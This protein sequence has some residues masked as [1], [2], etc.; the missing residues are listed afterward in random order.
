MTTFI[1][2]IARHVFTGTSPVMQAWS[3]DEALW[4][5]EKS[6]KNHKRSLKREKKEEE[7]EEEEED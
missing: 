4:M 3:L 2:Y 6:G 1:E 7:E 5:S